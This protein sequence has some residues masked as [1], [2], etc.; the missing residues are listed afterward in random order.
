M[1][2][3]YDF[4]NVNF[5]R[6]RRDSIKYITMHDTGNTTDTAKGNANYFRDVNRGAS[7]HYFVDDNYV[8]Q[9]VRE[10]DTS[11]H[12]GD[13]Y[14]KY[15]ITNDN[16]IGIEMCRVNGRVTEKTKANAVALVKELMDKYNIDIDHVV[17]HY[18]ASR[19]NCP[20]ALSANNWAEWYA[21][22][23]QI[24][25]ATG[26][27]SET[28]EI[29]KEGDYMSKI[30]QNGSTIE[31]VYSD[32]DCTKRLG[33]LNPW[34]KCTCIYEWEGKA[35]V[36]YNVSGTDNEKVGFVKWTGGIR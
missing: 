16:S 28:P 10:G 35:V 36:L 20:Q 21:L 1:E 26:S 19:K 14:G 32:S 15:G 8:V 4:T 6:G 25:K 17:R 30:Y 3:I 7:A 11:W 2:L 24:S 13:G 31:P 18:D 33:C 27:T 12:C 22:K 34:E 29:S 9:V 23:N 5:R